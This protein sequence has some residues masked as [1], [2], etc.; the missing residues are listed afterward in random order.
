MENGIKKLNV[1]YMFINYKSDLLQLQNQLQ[2]AINH[3]GLNG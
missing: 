2:G 1:K 3:M